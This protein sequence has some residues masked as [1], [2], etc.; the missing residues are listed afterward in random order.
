MRGGD[1]LQAV[2]FETG[3]DLADHILGH[4]VR[5]DDGQ[6]AFNSHLLLRNASQLKNGQF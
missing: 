4:G 2:A 1:D 3:I 5:F 6:G